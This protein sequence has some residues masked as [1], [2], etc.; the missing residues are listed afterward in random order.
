MNFRVNWKQ[1]S[2]GAGPVRSS[3]V[4]TVALLAAALVVDAS[5]LAG[6]RMESIQPHPFWIV[7]LLAASQY[8][9]KAGL[10][11]AALATLALRLFH[12]PP[13]GFE[14]DL[15]SWLWKAVWQPVAWML[16]AGGF[17]A[18]RSRH[19]NRERTVEERLQSTVRSEREYAAAWERGESVRKK[20]EETVAANLRSA[21]TLYLAAQEVEKL[22][23]L[24]VLHG[25]QSM[26]AA[27]LSPDRFSLY[28]L[29]G[30][31]LIGA[32]RHGW[33]EGQAF[34]WTYTAGSP[35]FQEVIA[36]R[37]TLCAARAG[38]R[39][40]LGGEGVLA[41]PL[42]VEETGEVIGML[43]IEE[44]GF[45][46]LNLSA[47]QNF[48]VICR[49]IAAA[50]WKALKYQ[51]S[52][53]SQAFN[54]RTGILSHAFYEQQS[55]FL[56]RVARRLDFPLMT[57]SVRLSNAGD[58]HETERAAVAGVLGA[59][60]QSVLR[61]IDLAFEGDR[62]GASYTIVLV[63]TGSAGAR[64]VGRK[65][66]GELRRR[67]STT[68][69]R[70]RFSLRLQPLHESVRQVDAA[71]ETASLRAMKQALAGATATKAA[72][73]QGTVAQIREFWRG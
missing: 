65:L 12:L 31:R 19:R 63:N 27:G 7:V 48:D 23:P 46:A 29:D 49:W 71:R 61:G 54:T 32:L 40:A 70:A 9:T 18:L 50:Y 38:D 69:I 22:E 51:D 44:T 16:A 5:L 3:M 43:K 2:A 20:L 33:P 45:P 4:E 6:D 15:Y 25:A 24:D 64:V 34:P 68:A 11:A 35:L 37:K 41:G 72:P 1:L 57:L 8:G 21:V 30:R 56:T 42:V 66:E 60:V 58:L 52:H 53:L 14:Y 39:E 13:L 62:P 73:D 55:L 28:L 17:G 67:L 26:V 36:N 10:A 47:L 59:S